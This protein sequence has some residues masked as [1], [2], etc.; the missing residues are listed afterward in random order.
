M[1]LGSLTAFLPQ[2]LEE[3]VTL[4]V[5]DAFFHFFYFCHT[6]LVGQCQLLGM[7]GHGDQGLTLGP[8][9]LLS[10]GKAVIVAGLA[11]ETQAT[12]SPNPRGRRSN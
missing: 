10:G 1:S 4:P 2:A 12:E 7:L 6:A 9:S 3:S 5:G 8:F 11:T